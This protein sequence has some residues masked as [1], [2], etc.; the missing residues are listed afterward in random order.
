[1]YLYLTTNASAGTGGSTFMQPTS[2]SSTNGLHLTAPLVIVGTAKSKF[3][4]NATGK[5]GDDGISCGMNPPV[6]G[7]Q[8]LP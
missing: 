4:V 7:F 3:V 2:S 6:F 8:K 5:V 1:V